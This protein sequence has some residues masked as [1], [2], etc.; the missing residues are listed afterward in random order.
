[1]SGDAVVLAHF[2]E[3][4]EEL[5]HEVC[6]A[7]CAAHHMCLAFEYEQHCLEFIE[8]QPLMFSSCLEF[9]NVST[10]RGRVPTFPM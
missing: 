10:L 6:K 9:G 4:M 7:H 3:S 8:D 5:S 2:N 1:M